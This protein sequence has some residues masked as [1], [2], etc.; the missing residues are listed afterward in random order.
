MHEEIYENAQILTSADYVGALE[1]ESAEAVRRWVYYT[2]ALYFLFNNAFC[3]FVNV[4]VCGK[5][6]Y[7]Q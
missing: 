2:S 4:C 6:I 5:E 3:V 1:T 7:D